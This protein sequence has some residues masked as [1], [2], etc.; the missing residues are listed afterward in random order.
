MSKANV[1][2]VEEYIEQVIN[3]RQFERLTEFCTEDCVLHASPYV[4]VASI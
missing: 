1:K 4:S 3:R 2:I